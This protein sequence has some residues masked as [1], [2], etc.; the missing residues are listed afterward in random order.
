MPFLRGFGCV[1]NL[2]SSW[3]DHKINYS[4]ARSVFGPVVGG[5]LAE[6]VKRFPSIFHSDTLWERNPFLLP[7]LAVTICLAIT[8]FMGFLFFRET[9]I[10]YNQR[11]DVGRELVSTVRTT[12]EKVLLRKAESSYE[13]IENDEDQSD[14]Q[15]VLLSTT[16]DAEDDGVELKMRNQPAQDVEMHETSTWVSIPQT[17]YTRQVVLQ[18]LSVSLL[19]FHKVAS[20]T[21]IPVFLANA[22]AESERRSLV[23][24][25]FLELS[26]GFGMDT[27]TISN[28]LLTQAVVAIVSQLVAVPYIIKRFGALRTYRWTTFIFP[29]IYCLTPF[30]VKLPSPLSIIALLLDLWVKVL[31]VALGYVCSAILY[32]NHIR[33]DCAYDL[34]MR[35]WSCN[36]L[37]SMI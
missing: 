10:E 5:I 36:T 35:L 20:D 31:L 18:I 16:S 6:P 9:H 32:V 17:P 26:G 2:F 37:L 3:V 8:W 23:K 33:Q 22:S 4:I 28:V 15:P 1:S 30:V 11:Y 34:R 12:L 19:A 27:A 29:W 21:L 7:N 13:I 24:H 25:S 14:R